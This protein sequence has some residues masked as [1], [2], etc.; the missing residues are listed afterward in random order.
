MGENGAGKSTFIKLLLRIYKPTR[1]KILLNGIDILE[2]YNQFNVL[3]NSRMCFYI[4]HR[5]ACT[6]YCSRIIVFN[7]G[8]I[9][10]DGSQEN[11]L[12]LGG[13]FKRMYE[14]QKKMY[15]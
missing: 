13:E 3:Y 15:K 10:E 9:V 14:M 2:V 12:K 11:L 1:G 4:S 7:E 5:L 6:Q 8:K